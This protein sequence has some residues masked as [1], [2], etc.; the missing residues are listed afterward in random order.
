LTAKQNWEKVK[1]GPDADDVQVAQVKLDIAQ[2]TLDLARLTAP[3]AGTITHVSS[4]IGDL[5]TA[6]TPAFQ[7]DDISSL[8]ID[9]DVSEVDINQIQ[10]GQNVDLTFD[11]IVGQDYSGTVTK[12]A[13]SGSSVN[14]TVNFTIT[15]E[16]LDPSTEIKPGMTAAVNVIVNQLDDVLLVPSRAVRTM[17]GQ[18]IVYVLNNNLP[19]PQKVTLGAS[20]NSYSQITEG[21]L[22]EG[23]LVIL[24][25]PANMLTMGPG[26][27]AAGGMSVGGQE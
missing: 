4:Q 22:K 26:G 8:L 27:G 5:V 16:I 23:D 24:N 6:G 17:N 11:A 2:A 25:P 12:V 14:G 3:F 1:D 7:I 13:S 15:V 19:I 21:D 10:V 18:R 20:A 9:V